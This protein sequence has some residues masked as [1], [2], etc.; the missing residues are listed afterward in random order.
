MESALARLAAIVHKT[1]AKTREEELARAAQDAA[2]ALRLATT[3]FQESQKTFATARA[4]FQAGLRTVADDRRKIKDL[5]HRIAKHRSGWTEGE[6]AAADEALIAAK[7]EA[8]DEFTRCQSG[9]KDLLQR[10]GELK[11]KL[12]EAAESYQE[13]RRV[14][15]TCAPERAPELLETDNRLAAQT[16]RGRIAALSQE[17]GDAS[18][19]FESLT[20][21]VQHCQLRIW[22]GLYRKIQDDGT[23]TPEEAS[24]LFEIF[25]QLK[26]LSGRYKP[27]YIDAFRLEVR[28]DWDEYVKVAREDMASAVESRR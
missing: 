16:T 3:E 17:V 6:R 10:H 13:V 22:L 7:Q 9:L 8:D 5:Q 21:P 15:L 24:M 26:Y 12:D 20:R 27:G 14:Q 28:E 11:K 1:A 23:S 25:R 2:E 4:E 18:P 19:H